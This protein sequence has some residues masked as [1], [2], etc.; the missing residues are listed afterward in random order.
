MLLFEIKQGILKF[1]LQPVLTTIFLKILHAE[2]QV[3]PS[4]E[5]KPLTAMTVHTGAHTLTTFAYSR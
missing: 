1:Y 4:P 3:S 2:E 5:L